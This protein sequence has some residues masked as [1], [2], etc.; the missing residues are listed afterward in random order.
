MVTVDGLAG[1]G[2]STGRIFGTVQLGAGPLTTRTHL[3]LATLPTL[4]Q[5]AFRAGGLG[6]VR[7]LDY[8]T[9]RGQA[10][11]S[12]QTDVALTRRLIRPILFLD[13]GQAGR[14]ETLDTQKVLVGGGVGVSFFRGLVRLDLAHAITPDPGGFRVDL[15]FGAV[16]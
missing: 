1:A 11:W 2:R 3:G 9:Q 14:L 6:T 16:R 10:L 5:M 15:V 12:V 8:G 4:P 13:A 7:G